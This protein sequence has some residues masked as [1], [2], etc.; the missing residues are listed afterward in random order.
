[1]V[2]EKNITTI[3]LDPERLDG[4]IADKKKSSIKLSQ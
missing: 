1:M 3:S 2:K 4:A